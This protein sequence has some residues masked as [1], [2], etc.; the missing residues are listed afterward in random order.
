MFPCV[1]AS[2]QLCERG[3]AYRTFQLPCSSCSRSLRLYETVFH[4]LQGACEH[5][6]RDVLSTS[7]TIAIYGAMLVAAV[8]RIGAPLL[9]RVPL[10]DTADRGPWLAPGLRYFPA[11][12]RPNAVRAGKQWTS[13]SER[14]PGA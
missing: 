13:A 2:P 11:D 8:A 5:T 4:T 9:P 6:G 14:C 3:I 12:L 10:P 7:T 1:V